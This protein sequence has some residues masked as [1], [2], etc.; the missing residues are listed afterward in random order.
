MLDALWPLLAPAGRLL[1][2]VCSVFAD[3]AALQIDRFVARTRGARLL[4][5]AGRAADAVPG[6]A[7]QLIPCERLSEPDS[8]ADALPGVH[9]G[10]FYAL[11]EKER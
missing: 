2:A 5:L 1:Y 7:L 8:D 10:F 4:P 11:L 3:E 9:D 6:P